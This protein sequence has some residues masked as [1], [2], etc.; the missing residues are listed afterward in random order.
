[1]VGAVRDARGGSLERVVFAVHGDE[2]ERAF[3][4]RRRARD[5]AGP[6]RADSFKGT[7]SAREVAARDRAG[8]RAGGPRGDRA[9]RRRRRRGHDGRA[10][11]CS[12]AS[13]AA[14]RS[15]I[16]SAARSRP[17]SPCWPDGAPAVVEAAQA[18]GLGLVD[19]GRA[20][21][22]GGFHLRDRRA[23][24]RGRRGRRL[25]GA[26]GRRRLG[27]DRRRRGRA[28][29]ARRG[30]RQRRGSRCSATCARRSRTRPRVFGPQ[31][32]A[33]PATVKRLEQRL[34]ELAAGPR[35]T[36]A[37]CR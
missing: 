26:R 10:R 15:A 35:A 2:A 32:G 1:M 22:V 29:G 30:G 37:A 33:D 36:R 4:G 21:C 24:R 14:Q 6:R 18:S 16:R 11:P 7:F 31:K 23:D 25:A 20:R 19:R 28:R 3:A 13:C 5:P 12:A 9:A 17:R 34:D 8:L 27:H